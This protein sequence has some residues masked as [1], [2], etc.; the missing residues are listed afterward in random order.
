MH[1]LIINSRDTRLLVGSAALTGKKDKGKEGQTIRCNKKKKKESCE[2]SFGLP[3]SQKRK[4]PSNGSG[5]SS[6]PPPP[7]PEPVTLDQIYERLTAADVAMDDRAYHLVALSTVAFHPTV[8]LFLFEHVPLHETTR[9]DSATDPSAAAAVAENT[10]RREA[11]LKGIAFFLAQRSNSVAQECRWETVA[12]L[13]ELCRLENLSTRRP[14][15]TSDNTTG[16]SANAFGSGTNGA[17]LIGG[18]NCGV[19]SPKEEVVQ[20]INYYARANLEFLAQLQWFITAVKELIGSDT[21]DDSAPRAATTSSLELR[22]TLRQRSRR[23]AD[24]SGQSNPD[25]VMESDEDVRIALKDIIAALP[26]VT[27]TTGPTGTPD[28]AANGSQFP[29]VR[30]SNEQME[31]AHD[32][33]FIDASTT[34]LHLIPLVSRSSNLFCANCEKSVPL[35]GNSA[36]TAKGVGNL[37]RCSSC[38]AVYYCSAE[39]QRAHWTAAHRVPCKNYKQQSETVLAEYMALNKNVAGGG[40]K[41]KKNKSK[42]DTRENIVAVL[43]VPL[44]PSLFYETRRY[45]YDHRDASFRDVSFYDYFMKYTVRGS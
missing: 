28:G 23:E 2:R 4:M 27:F 21:A 6:L 42:G 45:L 43:E 15:V 10:R 26:E 11:V 7:R 38:R 30:W 39:C 1:V 3:H 9:S 37:L 5:A 34:M 14:G 29:I 12:L 18:R 32:L 25:N 22:R 31:Q 33:M 40:G 20:K 35:E 8:K 16:I 24:S 19:L 44:E 41:R 13:G 36:A 17:N